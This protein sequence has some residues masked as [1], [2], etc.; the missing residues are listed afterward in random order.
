MSPDNN[1]P[2]KG[3]RPL[4]GSQDDQPEKS[5]NQNDKPLPPP[6]SPV[7]S[8]PPPPPAPAPS[9]SPPPVHDTVEYKAPD[10]EPWE[11][12]VNNSRTAAPPPW[13]QEA[14]Q[15][16]VEPQQPYQ[17]QP[18]QPQNSYTAPFKNPGTA[19]VLELIGGIFGL[20]GIGYM[21]A[22]KTSQG[23]IR[24]IVGILCNLVLGFI[25]VPL[26]AGICAFI[27][28]PF[29]IGFAIISANS[30]KNYLT[31]QQTP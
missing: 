26:T 19:F 12:S 10:P 25:F 5:S 29:Y 14:T 7:S 3:F 9:S 23:V 6:S 17:Q 16:V 22:G 30:I 28:F 1:S 4:G 24:L 18:Y 8:P 13:Q 2:V 31:K 11:N 21:Y 27:A 20:F 15:K